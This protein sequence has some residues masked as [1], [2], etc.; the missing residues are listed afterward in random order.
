[1]TI[2]DLFLLQKNLY[3]HKYSRPHIL[4][5]VMILRCLGFIIHGIRHDENWDNNTSIQ[6]FL[7]K[8]QKV[9]H[10]DQ[11]VDEKGSLFH[12]NSLFAKPNSKKNEAN[13][14]YN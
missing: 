3:V 13:D 14:D 9:L 6:V 12:E 11:P 4:I 8:N 5:M 1:M 2:R 7:K 10:E